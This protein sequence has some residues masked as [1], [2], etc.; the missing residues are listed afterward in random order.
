MANHVATATVEIDA[1]PARVWTALTDPAEIEKY[2]FGSHVVTDWRPGS[3]IVWEGEYEGQ[4][5]EDKG[6]I[7]EIKPA[8]RLKVTHFSPLSGQEDVP[9]NYHTLTYELEAAG[10][11]TRV[12]L[13][14]DNNPTAEAAEHSRANWEK[15]LSGL[16]EVVETSE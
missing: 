14:Q 4:R 15:M 9:E 16:K 7:V 13:S 1:S 8:R 5:Y 3:P 2:M 11:M 6:E 12:A 10:P